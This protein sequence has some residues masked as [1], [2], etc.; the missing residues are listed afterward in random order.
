MPGKQLREPMIERK[1]CR[2]AANAMLWLCVMN[3]GPV[4]L[5]A[6]MGAAGAAAVGQ[7]DKFNAGQAIAVG[8]LCSGL[9]FFLTQGFARRGQAGAI[10]VAIVF[11]VLLMAATVWLLFSMAAGP[12][13]VQ[14]KLL[15][16]VLGVLAVWAYA[17]ALLKAIQALR[18][19]REPVIDHSKP[20]RP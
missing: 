13:N 17:W 2:Q 6:A 14:F 3:I 20:W 10:L 8:L 19:A 5:L 15:A 1:Y 9:P 7:D 11:V 12:F 18:E 4:F 16:G